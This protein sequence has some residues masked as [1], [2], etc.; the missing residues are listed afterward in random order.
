MDEPGLVNRDPEGEAWFFRVEPSDE[1][2]FAALMDRDAYD[3][4][5]ETL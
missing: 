4:F 3:A 1:S 5:L 2:A